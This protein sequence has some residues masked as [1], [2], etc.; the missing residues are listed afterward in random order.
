[1]PG[2]RLPQVLSEIADYLQNDDW[3]RVSEVSND[4]SRA[5]Y[6]IVGF[7]NHEAH[8]AGEKE[9][10][11]SE[12]PCQSHYGP[13]AEWAVRS[14]LGRDPRVEQLKSARRSLKNAGVNSTDVENWILGD[15]PLEVKF[16]KG[17]PKP[18]RIR[19][20]NDF[21]EALNLNSPDVKLSRS[22]N[23]EAD[24]AREK[25]CL[26]EVATKYSKIVE[27]WE[28]LERLPF[29]DTQLEEASKTFLYGFYR[30]TIL[31]CA[32]AVETQ[33]K[34]L[35]PSAPD[36]TSAFALVESAVTEGLWDTHSAADAKD[37]FWYRNRVAHDESEPSS[38]EAMKILD[39][40]RS[41]LKTLMLK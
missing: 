15:G 20:F 33:L 24:I 13:L 18:E 11:L 16:A 23:D 3:C 34:R 21:L 28:P 32:S 31:L 1:M 10:P 7:K 36:R 19:L 26:K 12:F 27:R 9:L 25:I 4:E 38:K 14:Q 17:I 6:Y 5:H 39:S 2:P 30:S 35:M 29:E 8:V 40:C 22:E 41:L 37:L